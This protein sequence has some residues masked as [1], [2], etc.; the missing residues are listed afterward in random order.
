MTAKRMSIAAVGVLVFAVA[1]YVARVHA[2]P[3]DRPDEGMDPRAKPQEVT[4]TGRVVDL[5]CF[6]TG[7]Y[8]TA[9]KAK[10]TAD[11]LKQGV[12]A[13][14][15]T[16]DGIIILGQGAKGPASTLAPLAF[17]EAEITGSLFT[18]GNVKYLDI[19]SAKPVEPKGQEEAEPQRRSGW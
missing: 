9:D 14:L 12:P 6:M 13:G 15:A 2:S 4:L 3:Q 17:Q 7:Q 10:S 16:K 1:M 11:A 8:P 19:K 18:N 5:H